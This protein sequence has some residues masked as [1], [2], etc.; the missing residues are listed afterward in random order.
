MS[1]NKHEVFESAPEKPLD[2]FWLEQG[3]KLIE[4]SIP[5]L[6]DAAKNL[7]TLLGLLN[8]LYMGI[9]AFTDYTTVSGGFFLKSAYGLP[10]ICWLASLYFVLKVVMTRHRDI[11][12]LSPED[13]ERAYIDIV[14]TKQFNLRA[15]FWFITAG[16]IFAAILLIAKFYR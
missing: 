7:I 15:S 9:L 10:L 8:T 5:A 3:K 1:E 2:D 11:N 14:K 16:L 13:I 4:G 6:Q 12:P